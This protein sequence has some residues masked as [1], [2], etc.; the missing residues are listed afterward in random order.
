VFAVVLTVLALANGAPCLEMANAQTQMTD[1][2]TT[3]FRVVA[4][5]NFKIGCV[6]VGQLWDVEQFPCACFF[7][8]AVLTEQVDGRRVDGR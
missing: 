3:V 8:F 5:V 1:D 4:Q 7:G 2:G 6:V